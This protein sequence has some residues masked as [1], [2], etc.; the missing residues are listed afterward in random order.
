[1]TLRKRSTIGVVGAVILIAIPTIAPLYVRGQGKDSKKQLVKP[2]MAQSREVTVRGTVVCIHTYITGEAVTPE[3][4]KAIGD[5][6]RNGA[7]AGLETKTGLV[8]LGQGTTNPGRLLFPHA[9]RSVKIKGRMYDKAGFKYLDFTE[10]KQ[11]KEPTGGDDDNA[12]DD[13]DDDDDS[14]E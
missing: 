4:M 11:A 3:K 1:M 2:T 10:V 12:A 7:P 6:I 9:M 5:A 8:V 14:G 13:D